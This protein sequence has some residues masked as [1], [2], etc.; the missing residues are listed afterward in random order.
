MNCLLGCSDEIPDQFFQIYCR[1]LGGWF[2]VDLAPFLHR[3]CTKGTIEDASCRSHPLYLSR[4][5]KIMYGGTYRQKLGWRVVP[6]IYIRATHTYLFPTRAAFWNVMSEKRGW[7]FR[8]AGTLGDCAFFLPADIGDCVFFLPAKLGNCPFFSQSDLGDCPFF[9]PSEVI[10]SAFLSQSEFMFLSSEL[11][12]LFAGVWIILS[13]AGDFLFLLDPG[14]SG[15]GVDV[16][17][18][19]VKLGGLLHSLELTG[20]LPRLNFFSFG[21][22]FF[23][24]FYYY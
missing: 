11:L 2:S 21:F 23:S 22:P 24:F 12:L 16:S 5:I 1:F 17:T 19:V 15:S 3:F 20:A 4:K 18:L 10:I 7:M 8:N 13:E 14:T 9:F 6:S